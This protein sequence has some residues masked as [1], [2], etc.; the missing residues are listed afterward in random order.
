M[1]VAGGPSDSRRIA[2]QAKMDL[3][4][5]L[6]PSLREA[7]VPSNDLEAA[8]PVNPDRPEVPGR[9]IGTFTDVVRR[10]ADQDCCDETGR[11]WTVS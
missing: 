8:F 2:I 10:P 9:C 1:F 3:F 11:A 6:F 7:P 5:D 4:S